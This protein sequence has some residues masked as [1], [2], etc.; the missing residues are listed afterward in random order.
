MT[1]D[2]A[3]TL[4]GEN[5]TEEQITNLLNNFHNAE[6]EK[7]NEIQQL[8]SK[9]DNQS[10]YDSIKSELN[11]IN[12]A[13]MSEQEKIEQMKKEVEANLRSSRITCNKAKA[14]EILAG[15]DVDEKL[16]EK[17]VTDNEE[18]T[19]SNANL[20]KD[21]LNNLKD[22]VAKKTKESLLTKDVKPNLSNVKQDDLKM[23]LDKFSNLSTADQEDFISKYPEEFKNLQ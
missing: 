14:K 10:D 19:I 22:S 15:E 20:F 4:L 12:Q 3:K 5:A 16:I 6:K 2:M 8:K 7:D 23:T 21:T 18:D 9:L 13:K 11:Q 1:R 17:L